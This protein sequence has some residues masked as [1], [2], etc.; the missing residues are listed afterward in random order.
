MVEDI[1]Y[2][3]CNSIDILETNKKIIAYK[4]THHQINLKNHF[5]LA[6]FSQIRLKGANFRKKLFVTG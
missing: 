6:F 2:N 5:I 3:L 4:G 1:I